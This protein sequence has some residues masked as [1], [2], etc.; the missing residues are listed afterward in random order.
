MLDKFLDERRKGSGKMRKSLTTMLNF[1]R[2]EKKEE[3]K[4][5]RNLLIKREI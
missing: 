5:E 2:R 1:L 3:E 4:L